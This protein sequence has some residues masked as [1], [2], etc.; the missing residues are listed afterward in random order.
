[1]ICDVDWGGLDILESFN[2]GDD[3][4]KLEQFFVGAAMSQELT[5][6]RFYR[7]NLVGSIVK[8]LKQRE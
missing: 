1:M 7:C 6:L 3:S 4:S 8:L 2:G 5:S